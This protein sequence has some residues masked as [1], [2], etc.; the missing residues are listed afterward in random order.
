LA[1]FAS[2]SNNYGV[3]ETRPIEG[4]GVQRTDSSEGDDY[5]KP[6][7]LDEGLLGDLHDGITGCSKRRWG[8]KLWPIKAINNNWEMGKVTGQTRAVGLGQ[9]R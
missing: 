1:F 8:A 7:L 6:I 4:E 3:N 5:V 9:R 2:R